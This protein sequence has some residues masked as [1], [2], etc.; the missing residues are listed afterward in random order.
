MMITVNEVEYD[1]EDM[2]KQQ[3]GVVA[4]I[5]GLERA[6]QHWTNEIVVRELSRNSLVGNKDAMVNDLVVS[7]T[8]KEKVTTPK[9]TKK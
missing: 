9:G 2:T 4:N 3:R 8:P 5:Q 6:I 7:L 1:T